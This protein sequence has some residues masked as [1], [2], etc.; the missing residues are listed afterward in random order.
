MKIKFLLFITLLFWSVSNQAQDKVDLNLKS[1]DTASLNIIRVYPDDFPKVSIVFNAETSTGEPIWNLSRQQVQIFE[2]LNPCPIHCLRRIS[3]NESVKIGLVVDHSGSMAEDNSQLFNKKGEFLG[4]YSKYGGIILP[5]NYVSPIDNAKK[6]VKG[7]ITS[8]DNDKDSIQ[9]IGFSEK[10]DKVIP[11]SNDKAVINKQISR[12]KPTSL[13]AFYDAVKVSLKNIKEEKGIKVI[14]AL[15]DG[16]DNKSVSNIEEVIALAKA[17]EV[18]IYTVALGNANKKALSRM[19]EETGGTFYYTK[20]SNALS[21][22][23]DQIAKKIRSIYELG[24][25]SENLASEAQ[26]DFKLVFNIDSIY[27]TNNDISLNL[28]EEVVA[29][30]KQREKEAAQQLYTYSGIGIAVILLAGGLVFL[31]RKRK[32]EDPKNSASVLL[33]TYP[34]PFQE[35]LFV[36]YKI[37]GSNPILNL[38]S[39]NGSVVLSRPLNANSTSVQLRPFNLEAGT[40]VLTLVTDIGMSNAL[41]VVR[42]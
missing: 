18:P 36:N 39:L 20:S 4:T 24:Y 41:S 17:L 27:L 19:S 32:K 14:I 38:T 29:H 15:S 7:F 40:Y 25:A 12:M 23:Y 33:K 11:F 22:I 1:K 8:M 26:R 30:L 35:T 13:T 5:K 21:E 6:A 16:A 37:K 2:G 31:Y 3:E 42:G 10:V 9:V 28:S 34:N